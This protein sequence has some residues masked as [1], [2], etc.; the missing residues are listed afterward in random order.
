[1][2]LD[3]PVLD[4]NRVELCVPEVGSEPAKGLE[5][6]VLVVGA[7]VVAGAPNRFDVFPKREVG[8]LLGVESVVPA[9]AVPK[10]PKLNVGGGLGGSDIL[11]DDCQC[12]EVGR[13]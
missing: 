3:W 5:A 9:G 10:L 13:G 11:N 8:A 12:K 6:A 4:P 2:L 7:A 1:M